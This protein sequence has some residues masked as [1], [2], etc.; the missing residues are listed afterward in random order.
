MKWLAAIVS[1]LILAS[2]APGAEA[3]PI[4]P[5][6]EQ[7]IRAAAD[8]GDPVL[9]ASTVTVA[10]KAHPRSA[11][12]ID[13]LVIKLQ[14]D[15]DRRHRE[16]LEHWGFFDGWKGQ[17]QAGFNNTTGNT[18]SLGLAMG[19]SFGR[20][21]LKW[22]HAFNSTVDYERENGIETKSRYFASWES[23]YKYSERFYALGLA[24]FES[25]RFSGFDRRFSESLG[26]GYS[27]IKT[28]SMT[29]S[30][31][32]GPALRQTDYILDGSK[33]EFA[34]MGAVN[35]QWTIRPDLVLS[36]NATYYGESVD[37]T[38]TST[39]ALTMKLIGAL[40]AQASFL[41]QY[42]SNPPFGLENTNTTSRLTLVYSF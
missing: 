35:F 42:E 2:F 12:E 31:Q 14:A 32:G 21:G 4:P 15:A 30:I 33:N 39:T 9:M 19:L 3:D 41:A 17:G 5:D 10:K 40:S 24:S 37:S 34:G 11:A 8:S 7:M 38:F 20:E 18:R 28:P 25:D 6:V 1:V 22:R 36:E 29:L 26:L 13:K 16:A 23:D 27:I